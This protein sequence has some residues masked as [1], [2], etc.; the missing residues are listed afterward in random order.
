ME[1]TNHENNKKMDYSLTLTINVAPKSKE[2]IENLIE[3]RA[4]STDF[5]LIGNLTHY[6]QMRHRWFMNTRS[7]QFILITDE[8]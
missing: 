4:L 6:D 7:N 5:T 2:N 8:V 3:L 1:H